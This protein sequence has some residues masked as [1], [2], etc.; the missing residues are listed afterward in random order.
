M[1]QK[2]YRAKI[3]T[4]VSDFTLQLNSISYF[5]CQR[6]FFLMNKED[7]FKKYLRR[8]MFLKTKAL[9]NPIFP[10]KE[11]EVSKYFLPMFGKN[12]GKVEK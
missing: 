6:R 3:K 8:W 11:M 12:L 5:G 1:I 4:L 9:I 7:F 2:N 10:T